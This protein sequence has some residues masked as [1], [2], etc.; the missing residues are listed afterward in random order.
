MPCSML[1]QAVGPIVKTHRA[2]GT[3]GR[4]EQCALP[5]WAGDGQDNG[6]RVMPHG[7]RRRSSPCA[8]VCVCVCVCFFLCL[9]M[10]LSRPNRR[11]FSPSTAL[12]NEAEGVAISTALPNWRREARNYGRDVP[13]LG[14]SSRLGVSRRA[15]SY[16][17]T[18]DLIGRAAVCKF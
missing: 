9:C 7:I 5:F 18:A 8:S 17:L 16:T 13:S 10:C 6:A 14:A 15:D 4:G 11:C 1:H 12:E 3:D 2:Q